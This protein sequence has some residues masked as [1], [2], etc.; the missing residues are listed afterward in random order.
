MQKTAFCG[1][2]ARGS[3]RHITKIMLVMRLT[4]VLL[5]AGFLNVYSNGI[6]QQVTFSGKNVPLESVFSSVKQQTGFVFLYGESVLK[7][8]KPVTVSAY[9]EPLEA[10]LLAIFKTQP[11]KYVIKGK[12]ILVSPQSSPDV[13]RQSEP[14][15]SLDL[16]EDK[17][18][19]VQ[20]RVV[21]ENGEPLSGVTIVVKGT[22]KGVVTNA[23]GQ[24]TI[25]AE[26]GNSLVITNIGYAPKELKVKENNLT[27]VLQIATSKLDEVQIIPYGKTSQRLSTADVSTL[28]AKDIEK[29]P[30][31]NPML[32][33]QGR[34]PGVV[35]EQGTG[36]AGGSIAVK[37]RGTNSIGAGNDP[38][39]V[40]DGIPIPTD[41]PRALS[42]G[43]ILSGGF[44]G[45]MSTSSPT[46]SPLSLI[47]PAD[48]ESI[49][50]LKDADATAIYG[51]RGAN[52]VVVI[53]TKKGKAGSL[54][55]DISAQAGIGQVGRRL[56]LM[57]AQQYREMRLEAYK[58]DGID[59]NS[60]PYN[61]YRYR[62]QN[63]P[64]V[65][66]FWDTAR[67]T[68][69]QDKL[70]GNT[71]QYE[72]LQTAISGGNA[73]A[74]YRFGAAYHRETTVFPR[75]LPYKKGSFNFNLTSA[76]TNQKF[77]FQLSAAYV[78]EN[79][80]LSTQDFTGEAMRMPPNAPPL[81][82]PDGSINWEPDSTGLNP[83][84]SIN[85]I[86]ST[87]SIYNKKSANLTAGSVISYEVLP[88]LQLKTSLGANILRSDD[89]SFNTQLSMPPKY[90]PIRRR[91]S[92]FGNTNI[93][94]WNIEPQITYRRIIGRGKLDALIGS[95]FMQ[96]D[97]Y[98]IEFTASGF[99]TD[100]VMGDLRSATSITADVSEQSLY[101]YN[102]FFGRVNYNL[103]ERY[104]LSLNMRRDGSSRFGSKN[105]FHNFGS[106][107][108]AWI[109]TNEKF[110]DIPFLSFGKLKASYGTTGNDAIGDYS[111]LTLY[112]PLP[113]PNPYQNSIG[114]F[115]MNLT[116]PYL[117]WEETKKLNLSI[118]LGFLKDRI[119]FNA[120]W[121]QN[122]SSNQLLRYH[123]SSFTGFDGIGLNFPAT[124]QNSGP[125]LTL[126]AS[127]IS[128]KA[129]T[130]NTSLNFSLPSN[131]L[132]AF[133][134]LESSTYRKY[135]VVGQSIKILHVFHFIGVDPQTGLYSFEDR[136]GKPTSK[137]REI[138]EQTDDA[139]RMVNPDQKYYGGW[140]NSFSYKGISLEF[141]FQF[142]KQMGPNMTRFG[143]TIPGDMFN[144]MTS[145]LNH[146]QKPGDITP[147]QKYTTG[148]NWD[149]FQAWSSANTRSDAS[150]TDAS[151][152]RLK[153][154]SLSWEVP[155]AWLKKKY[156]QAC[157]VFLHGQN[158]LTFT[159]YKGLDPESKSSL[160]LPP[161]RVITAGVTVT[162]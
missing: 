10:F 29:Q 24:F 62:T 20:G 91:N 21:D 52:G 156:L 18:I 158:L 26:E 11:L 153:N 54:K 3:N 27:I 33:L 34:V 76:S 139:I 161:L 125:E 144:Q 58:N 93:N 97:N 68:N 40:V 95:T 12:S 127:V 138:Y 5:T 25:N 73:Q 148:S 110:V 59:L 77:K 72:D 90:W 98:M 70:F 147:I 31:S 96:R 152:I 7:A 116:N 134:N 136:D 56:Q 124:V 132:V 107:A 65:S 162:L 47:N 71:A 106:A 113:S 159:P 100:E 48:I 86:A 92:Y 28:K 105:R 135:L 128:H 57:N 140:Q 118:D 16:P 23:L 146:W 45:G 39:Y 75:A 74:K 15:G 51:T 13:V 130:W 108:A 120:T 131:K 102:A 133:P 149:A 114:Y 60:P 115:P 32:A 46:G 101:K 143:F 69:W 83:S 154:V 81:Y 89:Y 78:L 53:T 160:I 55:V 64:S 1:W 30:L 157:Q 44:G 99:A 104:M 19:N 8:A 6:A 9:G 84:F 119:L 43:I 155:Q 85:P 2:S 66:G 14:N 94:T 87:Y 22:K 41:Y 121:Y 17:L 137:P 4:F 126:S 117:Q 111:Y 79:N 67:T 145:I 35:I 129:F 82:R 88:G 109:F 141:L 112:G 80:R 103:D 61:S 150:W 151:Y 49:D 123:L 122:R 37:I 63:Y 38:L 42:Q 36:F 142:A 50:I